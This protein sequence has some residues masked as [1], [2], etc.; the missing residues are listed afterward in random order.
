MSI[1]IT[2]RNVKAIL[3]RTSG[4]LAPVAS[5]SLNPYGGCSFGKSLCGVACYARLQ[6]QNVGR[7]WGG[8]LEVRSNA[9]LVY[10]QQYDS[11]QQWARKFHE[12]FAI[13]MSSSTDPFVPQEDS[14]QVTHRLIEAMIDRPPDRL[15]IQTH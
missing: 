3:N 13:F 9:S 12:R 15:I 5:H 1:Q 11:E 4:F 7:E 14:F 2:E 8:Y 10:S 6:P